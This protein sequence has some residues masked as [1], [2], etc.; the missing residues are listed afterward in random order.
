MPFKYCFRGIHRTHMAETRPH[1]PK[2]GSMKFTSGEIRVN[3]SYGP[4][5][6]EENKFW[7]ARNLP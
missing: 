2:T 7:R 3:K 1:K 5:S 4:Q 6:D